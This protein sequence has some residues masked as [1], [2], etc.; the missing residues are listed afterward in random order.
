MMLMLL[1]LALAEDA[2]PVHVHAEVIDGY[3][4][5]LK[6]CDGV[7]ARVRN[8][9]GDQ[10]DASGKFYVELHN[11]TQGTCMYKELQLAGFAVGSYR[12][13]PRGSEGAGFAIPADTTLRIEVFPE[14]PKL[15]REELQ[16]QIAPGR[17]VV[18]LKGVSPAP[19]DA[20]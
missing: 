3:R 7:R 6:S 19:S 10:K 17:S 4:F 8:E 14:Q 16:L 9:P 11:S 1:A 2:P 18:L 20:P 15:K 5:V 13:L 12:T